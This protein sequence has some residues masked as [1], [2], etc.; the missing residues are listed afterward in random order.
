MFSIFYFWSWIFKTTS[1]FWSAPCKKASNPPT[2]SVHGM[3]RMLSSYW[4]AHFHL[5]KKSAKVQLF[6][7][8]GCGMMKVFT[9]EPQSKEQL[10]PLPH[11]WNTV[12]RKRSR[13]EHIQTMNRTSRRLGSILHEAAQNFEVVSNIRYCR[14]HT[15]CATSAQ[16]A[17]PNS[18][19]ISCLDGS[20]LECS[21]P[22]REARV[23]SQA[24]TCQSRD[25]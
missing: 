13:L 8:S 18:Q 3:H 14:G 17:V 23:R 19:Q 12:W 11:L 20:F 4:L 15:R 1:K 7:G 25:L 6:F 2:C 9:C 21:L 24:G 5:M 22:A 10:M 16:V